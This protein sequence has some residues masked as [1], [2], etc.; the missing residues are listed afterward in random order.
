[1]PM[2]DGSMNGAW[3]MYSLML[4]DKKDCVRFV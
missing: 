2:A 3:K 1:M 4:M